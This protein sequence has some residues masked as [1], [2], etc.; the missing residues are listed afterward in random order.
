MFLT[1]SSLSVV[2]IHIV[3]KQIIV[4]TKNKPPFPLL[5]QSASA[6]FTA[7]I[8]ASHPSKTL[9]VIQKTHGA[10]TADVLLGT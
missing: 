3:I 2:S 7:D 1:T 9:N 6:N 4:K 8:E 5:K 10:A